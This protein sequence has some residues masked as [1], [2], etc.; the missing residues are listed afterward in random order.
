MLYELLKETGVS[1]WEG[2][3]LPALWKVIRDEGSPMF[4]AALFIVSK[5]WKQPKCPSRDKWIRNV[6]YIYIMD[7]V[8]DSAIQK[9][10]IKQ[11][12]TI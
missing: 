10:E 12:G 5:V 7:T 2:F 9:N 1:G 6:W 4:T 11:S 3:G 8:Y